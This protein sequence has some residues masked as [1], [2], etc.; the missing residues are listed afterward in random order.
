MKQSDFEQRYTTMR[1]CEGRIY[2]NDVVKDLPNFNRHGIPNP[3]LEKEWLIRKRSAQQ[4]IQSLKSQADKRILEV[5]CGNG[6]LISQINRSLS[7][8]CC[9]IDVNETEL[10][11]A[12]Q[13][14]G[15]QPH[16]TFLYADI[17]SDLF[18]EPMADVIIIASAIQ[19]FPEVANLIK[20][21]QSLLFA[22]GTIHILDS[23]FYDETQVESARERSKEYFRQCETPDMRHHYF[24][25][26]MNDLSSFHFEQHHNPKS[27]FNRLM[28]PLNNNSPFPWIVINR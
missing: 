9:G 18:I 2:S 15:H 19:Y 21:L 25:H 24:H 6:W 12:V 22:K 27:I 8:P 17:T 26:T 28:R 4:L 1:N 23:P 5:G 14:F 20:K 16:L 10:V 13:V 3:T 11:Q 7:N